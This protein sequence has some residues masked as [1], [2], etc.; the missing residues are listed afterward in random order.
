MTD[1]YTQ[2]ATATD[3]ATRQ[4]RRVKSGLVATW[5]HEISAR[6]GT[7]P[8]AEDAVLSVSAVESALGPEPD[9]AAA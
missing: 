5:I 4:H 8:A 3:A 7:G 2:D 6:H 1:T 9:R